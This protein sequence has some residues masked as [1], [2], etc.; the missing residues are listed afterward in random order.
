[1]TV[2]AREATDSDIPRWVVKWGGI[3]WRALAMGAVV[4]FVFQ[5]VQRVSTVAIAVVMALFLASVLWGPVQWL[6]D[7]AGWPPL[8]STLTVFVVALA[9]FAGLAFF[10]IPPIVASFGDLSE[11]LSSAAE[12]IS[13]WLITGP[14][15]LSE[16]QVEDLRGTITDGVT[17]MGG[18]SILGGA[19]L[20]V[21][22]VTGF[23]LA[24]IVTF[25]ILKDGRPLVSKLLERLTDRH[26]DDVNRG[27]QTTFSTL[28]RYMGGMALVGLFDATVIGIGLLVVGVPL[29]LPL[30]ILV[31][32]GAFFPLVGAFVSG[33]FAVAV[34]F[35]NGGAVD[36]LI[37]LGLITA[38]QQFEG[39]VILP[40]VFKQQMRLHPVVVVLAVA[41]GG[42]AFGI[43]GAFLAV[44]L[45]A[46]V[47]TLREELGESGEQSL[48]TIA[49][50]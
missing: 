33:L 21:E 37:I 20:V 1:M 13:D 22:F 47:I 34:A 17:N 8:A 39:D 3:A 41:V 50:G 36:A 15:G 24:M 42:I 27:L 9:L 35:V 30:S 2:P 45:I 49:R 18:A 44:P 31:F 38:V 29:V 32:F 4:F 5:G 12:S 6:V 7:R 46:V 10:T 16:T 43:I 11:D 28:S 40:L 19:T 26:A 23:F 14:L 48:L 25:F